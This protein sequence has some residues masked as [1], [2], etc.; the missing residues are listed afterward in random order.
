[1][2]K[3]L[4]I[5]DSIRMGYDKYVKASMKNVA[6][7]FS[8]EE[9]CKF[10]TYIL[11]NLHV[12]TDDLKLYDVD[13]VHWNA[14]LWDTLKIYDDGNLVPLEFYAENIERIC[15][16]IQFLFPTSI[17][18]FATTTP[19][20]EEG[21]IKKFE[22]RTNADIQKYNEKACEILAKYNVRINDLYSFLE[23]NHTP[24]HSDQTHFYT[25]EGTKIIGD[26]VTSVLCDSL[27]IDKGALIE[28]KLEDC[29]AAP[30]R[31][32]LD[33]YEQQGHIYVMKK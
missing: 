15:K 12:W 1:M 11:R 29:Q 20:I 21:F 30:C 2:K 9:N 16:R 6:E 14:G 7:V 10:T 8:P 25:N 26:K 27:N 32:D 18:I 33:L 22:E 17:Q 23:N 5:G 31:W 4:L 13:A 28:P 24:L 3:I 19:V